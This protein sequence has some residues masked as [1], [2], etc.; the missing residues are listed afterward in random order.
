M[1]IFVVPCVIL[2]NMIGFGHVLRHLIYPIMRLVDTFQDDVV[3]SS[4]I[5]SKVSRRVSPEQDR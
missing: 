5:L 1:L 4:E 2:E 3:E